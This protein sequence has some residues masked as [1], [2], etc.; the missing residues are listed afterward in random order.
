MA[1][2]ILIL[3]AMWQRQAR[4]ITRLPYFRQKSPY[5]TSDRG[6][7]GPYGLL[8]TREKGKS[9][10]LSRESNLGSPAYGQSPYWLMCWSLRTKELLI[11][12]RHSWMIQRSLG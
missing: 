4:F 2:C 8:V 9:V 12:I 11:N 6:I 7:C 1:R 10:S 3:N 5:F